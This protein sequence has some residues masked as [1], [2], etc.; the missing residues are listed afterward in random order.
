MKYII[1]SI[2]E[3][4]FKYLYLDEKCLSY[5]NL[6]NKFVI[7]NEESADCVHSRDRSNTHANRRLVATSDQNSRDADG[8]YNVID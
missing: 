6:L 1:E 4:N 3:M 7:S 5:H 8:Y 2:A